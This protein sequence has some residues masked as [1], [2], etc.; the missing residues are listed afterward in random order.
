MKK[1][2]SRKSSD[3][4]AAALH[5]KI[6]DHPSKRTANSPRPDR[7]SSDRR[8]SDLHADEPA[9]PPL[10]QDHPVTVHWKLSWRRLLILM[11]GPAVICV[12]LGIYSAIWLSG[13]HGVR[14]TLKDLTSAQSPLATHGGRAEIGDISIT[15]YPFFVHL[16][17][18][19]VSLQA[20]A[21]WGG[22]RWTAD[23]VEVIFKPWA[24]QS[25]TLRPHGAH[26]VIT[27]DGTDWQVAESPS[28]RLELTLTHSGTLAKVDLS[29]TDV[30]VQTVGSAMPPAQM[31]QGS[32]V[33]TADPSGA[34]ADAHSAAASLSVRLKN[35]TLPPARITQSPSQLHRLEMDSRLL[36]AWPSGGLA[37]L[38][39]SLS[40]WRD[41]GGTLEVDALYI[42]W[43]TMKLAATGT[44]ALDEELQPVGA[45]STQVQGF[46]DALQ[47]LEQNG[48][49]RS[50]DATMVRL[51]LATMSTLKDGVPTL[52]TPMNV[53]SGKITMG[54]ATLL[55]LPRLVW[56]T[57][58]LTTSA[59]PPSLTRPQ[60][61]VDRWGKIT[62]QQP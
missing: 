59:P 62:R 32:L 44:V 49:V 40:K 29:G 60:Y 2:F 57:G 25:L 41:E 28:V 8:A 13:A 52:T 27:A 1:P 45:L 24:P 58:A 34:T 21:A 12:L 38:H 37:T 36:G 48:T 26:H 17:L 42:D 47:R 5:D 6:T 55:E 18:P 11:T 61:E 50:R 7:H 51:V 46:F 53:Q 10:H 15:G 31:G 33:L 56:P 14:D 9:A 43:D 19:Q 3:S 30:A 39:D 22:W 54:P 20:P 35:V 4:S 23:S 16:R